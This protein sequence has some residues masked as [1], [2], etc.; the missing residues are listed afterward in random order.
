MVWSQYPV[1]T[2]QYGINDSIYEELSKQW[3]EALESKEVQEFNEQLDTL[4]ENDWQRIIESPAFEQ[5]ITE[6]KNG[7][8]KNGR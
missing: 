3:Q 6:I 7:Y 2:V 5:L 1:F 8:Q 4:F